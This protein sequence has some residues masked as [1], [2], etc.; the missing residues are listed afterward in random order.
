M[1]M[2]E[3]HNSPYKGAHTGWEKTLAKLRDRFYWP[4][5]RQDVIHYVQTC[6]PCQKTKHNRGAKVGY[7]H[8]LHIP[9]QPFKV[10]S[11]DFITG[12]PKL[13]EFDSIL[14]VV[15]KLTKYGIFIPT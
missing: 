15:Y 10:I 13:Q 11:L 2:R 6:D 8:P 4:S 1:M 9:E 3:V 5:M 14:V 7:L 12:L